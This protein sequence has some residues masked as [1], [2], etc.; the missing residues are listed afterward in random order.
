MFASLKNKGAVV[1]LIEPAN[2]QQPKFGRR[3]Q[4]QPHTIKGLLAQEAQGHRCLP[5][6]LRERLLLDLKDFNVANDAVAKKP[7]LNEAELVAINTM[8]QWAADEKNSTLEKVATV[9][10]GQFMVD[11]I[12]YL[13]TSDYHDVIKFLLD[14]E[15]SELNIN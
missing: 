7:T 6:L 12:E 9:I 11:S 10:C 4:L 14:C 15:N 1:K 13:E 3:T 5:T 8:M 2:D